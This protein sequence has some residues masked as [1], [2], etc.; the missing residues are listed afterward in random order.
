MVRSIVS[1]R[2]VINYI[3]TYISLRLDLY[4]NHHRVD[5]LEIVI[6]WIN[7]FKFN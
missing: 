2:Q 7:D 4:Y 5:Q 3:E 1:Y 6:K